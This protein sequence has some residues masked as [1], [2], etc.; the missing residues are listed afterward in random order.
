MKTRIKILAL[1]ILITSGIM[2]RPESA[3]A[4]HFSISFQVFYNELT[5]YGTWIYHPEFGYAWVPDV[6]V[7]FFPYATD[8]HWIYTYSGWTWVSDYSWGWAPFHYGRWHF[9]DYWGAMWIPGYEWAP[10]WV[11]WRSSGDYCGWAPMGPGITIEIAFGRNYFVP[12]RHW[13]FV[14]Y[15]DFGRPDMYRHYV[16]Y[17]QNITIINHTT[18]INNIYED[19]HG[20]GR[21][22]AG[23]QRQ[24]V[25]HRTGRNI[26]PVTIKERSTP[27]QRVSANEVEVYK[28]KVERSAQSGKAP[29]STYAKKWETME[30]ERPVK[31]N[32]GA[33]ASRYEP[34]KPPVSSK[35][36][37]KAEPVKKDYGN[38]PQVKAEP[39]KKPVSP[40]KTQPAKPVTKAD[41]HSGGKTEAM[42]SPAK[43]QP[44]SKYK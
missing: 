23:P 42:K 14:K 12:Y 31:Y 7:G 33:Q 27:G 20:G 25:E 43:T 39:V 3:R 22:I 10:A 29:A 5:P 11:I 40:A 18:I 36:P 24:E 16:H 32:P 37:V 30:K 6:P 26:H 8:G 35:Q 4:D 21:Y 1:F 2:M 15:H 17:E 19:H 44:A 28:P 41:N 38:H 9:D 13:R 34:T